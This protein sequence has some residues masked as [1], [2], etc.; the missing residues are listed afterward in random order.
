MAPLPLS[1]D[2]LQRILSSLEGW[3]HVQHALEKTYRF[4]GFC[5]AFAFIVRVAFEAESLGH[6]PE[7][8]NVYDRVTIRLST[9]DAGN[10]VTSL[11]VDLARRIEGL[12][13]PDRKDSLPTSRA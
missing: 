10:R 1:E 11:D 5:D 2:E 12:D 7:W 3:R 8:T 9:H 6:H 4:T 13:R